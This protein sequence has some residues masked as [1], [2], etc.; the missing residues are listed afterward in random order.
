MSDNKQEKVFA[1]GAIFRLPRE[2]APDFVKGSLAIKVSEFSAF[3][4]KH[5]KQDG[6][7]NLNL[8]VSAQGKAYVELDTWVPGQQTP[9]TKTNGVHVSS[10]GIDYPEADINP[11]DI[12]F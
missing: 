2:G 12:P 1:D 10:E 7:V 6:F 8:K 5:V 9:Q 3:I 4:A 11:E